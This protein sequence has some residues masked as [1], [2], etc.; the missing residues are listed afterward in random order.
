M[1][2]KLLQVISSPLLYYVDKEGNCVFRNYC[3]FSETGNLLL[4]M[5]GANLVKL[6]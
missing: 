3:L 1:L 5:A 6:I 2:K 4:R